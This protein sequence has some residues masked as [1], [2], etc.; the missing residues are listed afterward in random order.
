MK[1]QKRKKEK[2]KKPASSPGCAEFQMRVPGVPSYWGA[3]QAPVVL[4]GM[5]TFAQELLI[6]LSFLFP[7]LTQN[8]LCYEY[9]AN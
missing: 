8:V 6:G 7:E 3:H 4:F 9:E 1:A 2:N 5:R